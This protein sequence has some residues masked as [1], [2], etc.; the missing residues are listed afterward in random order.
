MVLILLMW[1]CDTRKTVVEFN[2]IG[3]SGINPELEFGNGE[4]EIEVNDS[5]YAKLILTGGEIG[6]ATLKIQEK[7]VFLYL[8]TKEQHYES[9]F[10][11]SVQKG[12]FALKETAPIRIAI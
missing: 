4:R 11:G 3:A 2:L 12:I 9:I 1:C 7:T 8:L 6:Y 5:G 10:T